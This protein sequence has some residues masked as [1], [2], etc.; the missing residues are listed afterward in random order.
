LQIERLELKKQF[1][2]WQKGFFLKWKRKMYE[3]FDLLSK[4]IVNKSNSNFKFLEN[5]FNKEIDLINEKYVK[6]TGHL[7]LGHISLSSIKSN[8]EKPIFDIDKSLRMEDEQITKKKYARIRAWTYGIGMG[9][10]SARI[11]QFWNEKAEKEISLISVKNKKELLGWING[12]INRDFGLIKNFL[13][14]EIEE[15]YNSTYDDL[16]KQI[17]NSFK[18]KI[19]FFDSEKTIDKEKIIELL[20]EIHNLKT[21]K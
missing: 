3:I 19:S 9:V 7:F 8:Q 11:A 14:S 2:H 13:D 16:S 21:L 5:S 17:K 10:L 6:A 4:E 18:S 1:D 15:I 12:I 20:N